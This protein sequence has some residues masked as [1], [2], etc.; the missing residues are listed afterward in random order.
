MITM[1]FPSGVVAN[2]DNSRF[3]AYGYDQRIEALGDK[4]MV[5]AMN[6]T[7]TSV[8]I[9]NSHGV[10]T[11]PYLYSFPQRYEKT[12]ASELA[13]FVKVIQRKAEPLHTRDDIRKVTI[14]ANACEK[15]CETGQPVK[16]T[17]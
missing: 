1:K 15:S 5:Q 13:H 4:G 2:I 12:Y 10:T 11:D 8:V 16:V 6:H 14:I 3:A 7:P 17:Y 9:S